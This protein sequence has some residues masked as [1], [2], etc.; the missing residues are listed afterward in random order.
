MVKR[1]RRQYLVSQGF[2]PEAFK[3]EWKKVLSTLPLVQQELTKS[4]ISLDGEGGD[5]TLMTQCYR[6]A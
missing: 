2:L 4:A 5:F 3:K 1:R 6:V